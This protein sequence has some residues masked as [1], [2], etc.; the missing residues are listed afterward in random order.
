MKILSYI[1]IHDSGL[2]INA[3]TGDSFITNQIGMSIFKLLNENVSK[4]NIKKE[5]IYEYK[6]DDKSFEKSY[7]DFLNLLRKFQLIEE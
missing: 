2:I 6:I 5:I 7:N 1:A 3:F 4:S